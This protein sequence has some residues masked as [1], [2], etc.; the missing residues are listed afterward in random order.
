MI[1]QKHYFANKGPSSQSYDFSS[2]H[3][4]MW[5]VDY[6]EGWMLKN[7]RFW[8]VVLEKTLESPLNCKIKPVHPKGNQ[9][10]IFIGR[11]DAKAESPI[12][13][14]PDT[15]SWLRRKDPDTGKHWRQGKETR[16]ETYHWLN[17]HEFEQAVGDGEGQEGLACCS[18]WGLKESNV[19]EWLKNNS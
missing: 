10:W 5:E 3:V 7:W 9:P 1:K 14:P 11:T 19:I 4:W 6:K 15:K 8:T 13:W 2:S 17:G 16:E 18:P 12:L